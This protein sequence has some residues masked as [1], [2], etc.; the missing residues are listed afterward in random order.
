MV[1]KPTGGFITGDAGLVNCGFDG[2]SVTQ[3]LCDDIGKTSPSS[4]TL[5]ATAAAGYTFVQWAGDCSGTASTCTVNGTATGSGNGNN[6]FRVVAVF[7]PITPPSSTPP[8]PAI[9]RYYGYVKAGAVAASG[10][11]VTLGAD[12]LSADGTTVITAAPT[13]TSGAN[14]VFAIDAAP[15]TYTLNIVDTNAK[16]ASNNAKYLVPA[17]APITIPAVT[18]STCPAPSYIADPA[19]GATGCMFRSDI[20]VTAN[21][22]YVAPVP[23]ITLAASATLP[24][25]F[26]DGANVITLPAGNKIAG[27]GQAVALSCTATGA[28]TY[29]VAWTVTAG[30]VSGGLTGGTGVNTAAGTF[31]TP[32]LGAV[33]AATQAAA[34]RPANCPSGPGAGFPGLPAAGAVGGNSKVGCGV[35]NWFTENRPG[36][37]PINQGQTSEF[38]YTLTCTA[39]DVANSANVATK[40]VSIP[41]VVAQNINLGNTLENMWNKANG[42]A[43]T[44][45]ASH[46]TD[47]FGNGITFRATH[48]GPKG[49]AGAIIILDD[50]QNRAEGYNWQWKKTTAASMNPT[51][52]CLATPSTC[53]AATGTLPYIFGANTA[54]PWFIVP[55]T[56]ASPGQLV[57]VNAVAGQMPMVLSFQAN[58][59]GYQNNCVSCHDP[60][61][62]NG[63]DV[64]GGDQGAKAPFELGPNKLVTEWQGS[65]HAGI[66]TDGFSSTHYSTSCLKCHTLG[67]DAN[68]TAIGWDDLAKGGSFSWASPAGS[69][70]TVPAYSF[71]DFTFF[72]SPASQYA[73]MPVELQK[74]SNVQCESCH[75]PAGAGG[76]NAATC[77]GIGQDINSVACTGGGSTSHDA[78]ESSKVCGWCHDSGHHSIYSQWNSGGHADVATAMNEGPSSPCYSCHTAQQYINWSASIMAGA[79]VTPPQ[80]P[81]LET[82]SGA[83]VDQWNASPITCQACHEPHS[84]ELRVGFSSTVTSLKLGAAGQASLTNMTVNS[85]AGAGALCMTCHNSRRANGSQPGGGAE[86][87]SSSLNAPHD[88]PQTDVYQGVS[89]YW[90]GTPSANLGTNVHNGSF[91]SNSCADCHVILVPAGF[92]TVANHTFDPNPACFACHGTGQLPDGTNTKAVAFQAQ[93]TAQLNA[94]A[95]ALQPILVNYIAA[96]AASGNTV[97]AQDDRQTTPPVITLTGH[98]ISNVQPSVSTRN[99]GLAIWLDGNSS[100]TPD[101][102]TNV[103]SL[104]VNG[105]AVVTSAN[106][107]VWLYEAL[108]NDKLVTL[109]GSLGIHNM[110]VVKDLLNVTLAKLQA[111]SLQ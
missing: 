27:F 41:L 68:L 90:F 111:S 38:A 2:V 106:A 58:F 14:G 44:S 71:P 52:A 62:G 19:L 64:G 8:A 59:G 54:N 91:F 101:L 73:A 46:P 108:W 96:Q 12:V 98:T 84:L 100:A 93:T 89:M 67:Y 26:A 104:K 72:P 86:V 69:N 56:G 77:N 10:I 102:E 28:S 39:T 78:S 103:G 61:W 83:P 65:R 24:A 92:P 49:Q 80:V 79:P 16:D 82:Y 88:G 55:S 22:A 15:G 23:A 99:P 25:T 37:M 63:V 47:R 1:V 76:M 36:F 9:S 95:A 94:I 20:A 29:N 6:W 87:V 110:Y 109:D 13:A 97:T 81:V 48:F 53:D 105:T 32:T 70:F 4:I 30:P 34:A 42:I 31:T 7:N 35:S 43:G 21:G 60:K 3:T 74:R 11:K 17:P 50:V 45:T 107:N 75:G 40:T 51:A 66:V 18:D 5:T 85:L 33:F 57:N